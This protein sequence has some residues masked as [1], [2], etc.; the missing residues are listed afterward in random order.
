MY[1]LHKIIKNNN[2]QISNFKN[3]EKPFINLDFLIPKNK[4]KKLNDKLLKDMKDIDVKNFIAKDM[5]YGKKIQLTKL[6]KERKK[7]NI[8]HCETRRR[9]GLSLYH[10]PN[11]NM[12]I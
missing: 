11:E 6:N 10:I 4:I 12:K 1:L 3:I 7:D 5:N 2:P 9:R 8:T